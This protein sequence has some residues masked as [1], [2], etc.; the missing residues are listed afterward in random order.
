MKTNPRTHEEHLADV[1]YEKAR[2]TSERAR[3]AHAKAEADLEKLQAQ[4]SHL[5][6]EAFLEDPPGAATESYRAIEAQIADLEKL[7]DRLKLALAEAKSREEAARIEHLAQVNEGR[8][9]KLQGK[10]GTMAKFADDATN[11]I[12]LLRVAMRGMQREAAEIRAMVPVR[13]GLFND[14]PLTDGGAQNAISY[15]IWRLDNIEGG[16]VKP[17]KT[18]PGGKGAAALL[19]GRRIPSGQSMASLLPPLSERVREMGELIADGLRG[20]R[21][22]FMAPGVTTT[23]SKAEVL[24]AV[25][26]DQKSLPA[27]PIFSKE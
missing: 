9:K 2:A 8:I 3:N 4:S 10:I 16:V 25:A 23:G 11:A 24:K 22:E 17:E 13:I 6:I 12:E 14:F 18:L 21:T 5:A 7:R 1:A 26:R 19:T 20:K 15:E 27:K